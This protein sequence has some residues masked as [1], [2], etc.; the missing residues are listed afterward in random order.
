[1]DREYY[2]QQASYW[3]RGAAM[4]HRHAVEALKHDH[5]LASNSQLKARLAHG[6]AVDYLEMATRDHWLEDDRTSTLYQVIGNLADAAG[7]F[8]DPA[9]IRA[10]DLAAYGKTEDGL[11]VLPFYPEY[12]KAV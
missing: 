6:T 2:L 7:V 12:P 9:V 8:D 11:D 1:M 4:Y 5:T 10:L 3:Q